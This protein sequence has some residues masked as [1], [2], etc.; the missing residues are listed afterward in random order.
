MKR[1][2]IGGFASLIGTIWTLAVAFIAGS[3]L[4]SSWSTPPGRFMTTVGENGLMPI[5]VPAI[6]LTLAGII[7]MLV[8]LFRK[9]K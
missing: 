7:V 9:E 3:N 8:E 5:F 1:V 6:I 4:V 2:L